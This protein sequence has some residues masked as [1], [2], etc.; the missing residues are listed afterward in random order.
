VQRLIPHRPSHNLPHAL[1]LVK[2]G[3]VH[4]HREAGKQ[5]QAFGKGAERRHGAGHVALGIHIKFVHVGDLV[6]HLLVV[7]KGFVLNLGH[8]D[9]VQQVRVSR[10]MHGFNIRE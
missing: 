10:D 8:P 1:H 6:R 3:E 5:L 4:Q 7:H 2:P 9:G